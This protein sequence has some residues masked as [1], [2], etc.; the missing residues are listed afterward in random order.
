MAIYMFTFE[1]ML[2]DASD[3][4]ANFRANNPNPNGVIGGFFSAETVQ[5][6]L[7][8]DGCEGLRYYF[9]RATET[10]DITI[11]LTGVDASGN[12]MYEG[13]LRERSLP[14]PSMC[15]SENP[16]NSNVTPE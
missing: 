7:D 2:D 16:L 3:M 10:S 4:T 6:V 8:Q 15:S 12:D 1:I 13:E 5:E 9:A 11:V 14:C